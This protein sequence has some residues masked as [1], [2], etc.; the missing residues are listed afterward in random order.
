MFA[1]ASSACL[2]FAFVA[3]F[4]GSRYAGDTRYAFVVLSVAC[5]AFFVEIRSLET[6]T[7]ESRLMDRLDAIEEKLT[8]HDRAIRD[9]KDLNEAYAK[10]FANK[11]EVDLHMEQLKS[12]LHSQ[13]YYDCSC[14]D[15]E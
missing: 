13:I 5:L 12:E 6:E 8:D 1:F 2:V 10:Y 9:A 14:A 3:L 11:N 15:D 7:T 4:F